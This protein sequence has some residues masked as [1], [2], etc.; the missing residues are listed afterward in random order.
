MADQGFFK[1]EDKKMGVRLYREPELRN[2]DLIAGWPGIGNIGLMAVHTLARLL[3]A[4]EFGEIEP[5]DFFYP[6]KV[7]IKDGL[8]IDMEF[9]SNK[10]SFWKGRVRDVM[11]FIGEQQPSYGGGMYASGKRAYQIANLVLDVGVKFGCQRVYTSGACVSSVHHQMKPRVVSVVSSERLKREVAS[12]PNTIL[13]SQT[14]GREGNAH[15]Q[16]VVTGLN[17]LLLGLAKKRGLEAI[18][19]MG[20]IP[21]W[22]AGVS[23]PYPRASRSVLEVFADILETRIDFDVLDHM[24]RQTDRIVQQVYEH[25]PPAIRE[26]YDQR[27]SITQE[28]PGPITDEEAQWIADHIEELFSE[29][30]DGEDDGEPV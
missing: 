10:F 26:R 18:C 17:G 12:Y 27:K 21:E 24:I 30:G 11:F 29:A 22:L 25:F 3:E 28:K 4:E 6:G 1:E 13:M 20:E 8:L 2:P 14:E 23:I 16:G 5:W 7:S 15:G 19:L 9:P